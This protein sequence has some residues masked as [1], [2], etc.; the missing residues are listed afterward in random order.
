LEKF[1][2]E[3]PLNL[4]EQGLKQPWSTSP[5]KAKKGGHLHVH[6]WPDFGLTFGP[7][8]GWLLLTDFGH[9]W[10][11][12]PRRLIRRERP[13]SKSTSWPDEQTI[14]IPDHIPTLIHTE[15][16]QNLS[17]LVKTCQNLSKLVKSQEW[18]H[19]GMSSKSG[20]KVT[21]KIVKF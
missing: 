13:G 10:H 5:G 15:K 14:H 3:M 8:F 6:F 12:Q 19:T 17:K 1:T 16:C 20:A 4:Y 21:P 2:H 7:I 18:D 9:V 11:V